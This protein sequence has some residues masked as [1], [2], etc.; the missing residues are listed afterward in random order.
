MR[1]PC[2]DDTTFLMR[3]ARH[4]QARLEMSNPGGEPPPDHIHAVQEVVLEATNGD[5]SEEEVRPVTLRTED[6]CQARVC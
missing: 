4:P 6:P 1:F 5:S 2:A 3:R